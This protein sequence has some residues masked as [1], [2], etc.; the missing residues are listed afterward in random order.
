MVNNHRKTRVA[1]SMIVMRQRWIVG[2][3]VGAITVTAILVVGIVGCSVSLAGKAVLFMERGSPVGVIVNGPFGQI[4]IHDAL[5]ARGFYAVAGASMGTESLPSWAT[6]E[7][8]T[9][10]MKRNLGDGPKL[11]GRWYECASG[12]PMPCF[13]AEV[14]ESGIVASGVALGGKSRTVLAQFE[15]SD[16][17]QNTVLTAHYSLPR[18]VPWGVLWV[19]LLCN[20]VCYLVI[21]GVLYIAVVGC[22]VKRRVSRGLC[23]NCA[24]LGN[25]ESRC[26]ECGL[27]AVVG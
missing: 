14:D 20:S 4:V 8:G 26:P 18:M 13:F 19:G 6:S 5:G 2:G 11:P 9:Q 25:S 23:G 21:C 15:V 12:W 27:G 1:V 24:Y 17:K 7:I 22:V 3:V 10:A 16:E